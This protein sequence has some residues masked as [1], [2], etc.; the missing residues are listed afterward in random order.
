MIRPKRDD[1]VA[2]R[3]T[4]VA[5]LGFVLFAPPLISLFDR[6]GQVAGVPVILVYLLVVWAGLIALVAAAVR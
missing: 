4:A 6:G 3:S 2:A 1:R 5:A